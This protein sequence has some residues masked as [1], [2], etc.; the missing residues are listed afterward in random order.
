MS[1]TENS[2][3][4]QTALGRLAAHV[5]IEP[6]FRDA[7]GVDVVTSAETQRKL[8]AA[9]G[10]KA[11][12]EE[13][14]V[15]ALDRTRN[16]AAL[17]LP[18]VVV[19]R[20]DEGRCRIRMTLP[21]DVRR[22]AWR[23]DLEDGTQRNGTH[24]L[25][26]L[27][28]TRTGAPAQVLCIDLGEL[29]WGYHRLRVPELGASAS[30]VVT[31]GKCWLPESFDKGA[32]LWGLAVQLYLLRSE[33]NWG[34]GDFADLA[35]L[36]EATGYHGCD[37]IGLNPLHQMMLDSPE[38]ASP[39]S[40]LSRLYLNVL[41]IAVSEAPGYTDSHGLH[42]LVG[43]AEFQA[44]L[45]ACRAAP[46]VNYSEVMS[47]KLQALSI[48]HAAF[49]GGL[50]E[51]Q[52]RFESFR[53]DRDVS[54]QRISI[55]QTLRQHFAQQDPALTD[56]HNW[57]DEYQDASSDAVQ[58]FARDHNEEID[59][60][61]W[62]QW[63]ADE[64]LAQAARA[65]E[66]AGMA[67][68]LYRD[69]AVGCDRS[70]AETWANPKAFLAGTQVGAPP[71]IFN[72]AGQDWG[73]PP[74]HP[75]A[76]REEG[77][78][79]F[80]EL[81]RA[82]MR[83]AG[84]LRIDHVMGLQHLYCIPEGCSPA[85]GAYVGYAIDDLIGILALESHRHRC[86]VVGEDLGT[87]PEGFRERLITANILSYRVLFFEQNWDEGGFILPE[88]YPRLG[89]AVASN[90]DLPTL[91]GWWEGR[92]INLKERLG[93]YPSRDEAGYQR[94]LREKDRA[95]IVE[96]F[97]SEGLLEAHGE[98]SAEQFTIAAHNF[99][100]RSGCA[101]VVAQMDDLLGEADQVNVPGT[102]VQN[103]NWRRKYKMTVEEIASSQ[104]AW[105]RAA[106]LP[107]LRSSARQDH[108]AD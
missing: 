66:N 42:E 102:S 83:H 10:V 19:I 82:N 77:Y 7:R 47:L 100:A 17:A 65:A 93:L 9:M 28:Q 69:L 99:L 20:P 105:R 74:F 23:V 108:H 49:N 92:D 6:G 87:V 91:V 32:R 4:P 11:D 98:L 60:L 103:P 39:Y 43:S 2:A 45:A 94:D 106:R 3:A 44:R 57:P 33:Q 59:F 37:V 38:Q 27:S 26:Q 51:D 68:G 61:V 107:E 13:D 63:V 76:L 25:P 85:E 15:M 30:L 35:K 50:P 62:L 29:A 12:S 71:D 24:D 18:P 55:F 64:Q 16:A 72:P 95:S 46:N 89:L 52:R 40:P 97:R 31:P 36:L 21:H 58:R 75:N 90:H 53:K 67:I 5:G 70:G 81:I 96:A 73:L 56:W 8:L 41:Y 101:L 79:S 22:I 78:R 104:V 14:A 86:L 84:G 34:V 48:L 88:D 54:L 80:I 1:P